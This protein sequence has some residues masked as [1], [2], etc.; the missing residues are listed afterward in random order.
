MFLIFVVLCVVFVLFVIVLFLMLA[1]ISG[2][3]DPAVFSNVYSVNQYITRVLYF[4]FHNQD[5]DNKAN[6]PMIRD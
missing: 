2:L 5:I 1:C 3:F 4:L 6:V